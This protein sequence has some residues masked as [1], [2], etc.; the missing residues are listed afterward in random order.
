LTL[1]KKER[2]KNFFAVCDGCIA[3]CC[4]GTRPPISS[5][6]ERIIEEY[7]KKHGIK[8]ENPFVREDYVFPREQSNDYCIF[9]DKNTGMCII[10]SVKPETCVAGPVTFD[11]N[12]QTRKIEW[13]FKKEQ[14]CRLA[15]VMFND[16]EMFSK[17]FESAKKEIFKLVKELDAKALKAILKKDE[18]E[19]FKIDE[20][21]LEKEVLDK[22]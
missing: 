2:Q 6:R 14:I 20:D 7:L 21:E 17:H 22:L 12:K 5:K 4:H 13:F 18:P 10:H 19:T 15:G 1:K 3:E 9:Y 16:K 8:V 11:I